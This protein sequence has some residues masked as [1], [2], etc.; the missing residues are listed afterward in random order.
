MCR[1]DVGVLESKER[2]CLQQETS[3]LPGGPGVQDIDANEILAPSSEAQ[4]EAYRGGDDK[5][6]ACKCC[7][8]YVI[9]AV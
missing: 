2:H 4:A 9:C 1:C 5:P 8:C 3:P 6:G 7:V